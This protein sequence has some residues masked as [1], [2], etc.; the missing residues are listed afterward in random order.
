MN[1]KLSIRPGDVLALFSTYFIQTSRGT[2][3]CDAHQPTF[4]HG[5]NAR[6]DEEVHD[7]RHAPP[8]AATG[9]K[10]SLLAHRP[11]HDRRE[12]DAW[13]ERFVDAV[14]GDE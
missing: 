8:R 12:I 5:G 11:R 4:G 7:V 9:D 13:A 1:L 3:A 6:N 2:W 10:A 14:L